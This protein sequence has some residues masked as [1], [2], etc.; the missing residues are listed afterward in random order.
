MPKLEF[1]GVAT[2]TGFPRDKVLGVEMAGDRLIIR[3]GN[4]IFAVIEKEAGPVIALPSD[5]TAPKPQKAARPVSVPRPQVATP[6]LPT[7][8]PPPNAIEEMHARV[9]QPPTEQQEA[10]ERTRKPRTTLDESLV[11]F[12]N[13][14]LVN[15]YSK[16]RGK[17]FETLKTANGRP[18][19]WWKTTSMVGSLEGNAIAMLKV[20]VEDGNVQLL[21]ANA[22]TQAGAKQTPVQPAGAPVPGP[23]WTPPSG[24]QPAGGATFMD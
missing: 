4:M 9:A 22:A 10:P 8:T 17:F 3:A 14:N 23:N 16:L 20:F 19:S 12:V 5:F 6:P 18:V 21:P 1:S 15:P 11:I 7:Q 2:L 13:P 24:G